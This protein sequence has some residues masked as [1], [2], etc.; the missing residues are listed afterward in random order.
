[1][2]RFFLGARG[3]GSWWASVFL[4]DPGRRHG[5]RRQFQALLPAAGQFKINIR[6]KPGVLERAMQGAVGIIN[7]ETPAKGIQAYLSARKLSPRHLNGIDGPIMGQRIETEPFPFGI[8][9]TEIEFGI[10]DN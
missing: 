4:N 3:M 9:K 10:V 2:G 6:Q 5:F 7:L 1:M 8:E